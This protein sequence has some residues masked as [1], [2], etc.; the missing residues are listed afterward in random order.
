MFALGFDLTVDLL[1]ANKPNTREF[2]TAQNRFFFMQSK[3]DPTYESKAIEWKIYSGN[4]RWDILSPNSPHLVPINLLLMKEGEMASLKK[5]GERTLPMVYDRRDKKLIGAL[6]MDKFS[7]KNCS[8][9]CVDLENDESTEPSED[10]LI[11]LKKFAAYA[12][13]RNAELYATDDEMDDIREHMAP[14]MGITAQQL[15][16]L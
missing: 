9:Y 4:I 5:L 8:T 2:N 10:A 3:N 15:A 12:S 1:Q 13:Y 7:K 14:M 16:L 11:A 6:Q